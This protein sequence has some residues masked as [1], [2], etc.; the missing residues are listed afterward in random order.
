MALINCPECGKQVSERAASCPTCACPINQQPAQQVQVVHQVQPAL[1]ESGQVCPSCGERHRVVKASVVW[2][3]GAGNSAGT[4]VMGGVVGSDMAFGVGSQSGVNASVLAQ[5]L[6]PPAQPVNPTNPL[7]M[8]FYIGVCLLFGTPF[9]GAALMALAEIIDKINPLRLSTG[10][11]VL[12]PLIVVGFFV[13]VVVVVAIGWFA[14]WS[15]RSIYRG[16]FAQWEKQIA[17]WNATWYCGKCGNTF[18]EE[19]YAG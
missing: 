4:I 2:E 7:G 8:I 19:G 1:P 17:A 10:E 16:R 11:I 15:N 6:A 5:R 18:Y 9:L 3:Q 14:V 12:F 13:Y